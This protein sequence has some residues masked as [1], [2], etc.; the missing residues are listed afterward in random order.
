MH[1]SGMRR[2][3]PDPAIP[4]V[5]SPLPRRFPADQPAVLPAMNEA[6]QRSSRYRSISVCTQSP[7]H[8]LRWCRA[9]RGDAGETSRACYGSTPQP[10]TPPPRAAPPPPAAHRPGRSGSTAPSIRAIAPAALGPRA[11]LLAR[12]SAL[13]PGPLAS[14]TG[15]RLAHS[16]PQANYKATNSKSQR[17]GNPSSVQQPWLIMGVESP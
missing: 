17:M 12:G 2:S 9:S 8:A 5:T 10:H 4:G 3:L 11:P 14:A 15:W 1:A 7:P 13:P 16:R 6:A